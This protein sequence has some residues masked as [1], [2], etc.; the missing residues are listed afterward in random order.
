MRCTGTWFA[1]A[2]RRSGS[3]RSRSPYSPSVHLSQWPNPKPRMPMPSSLAD[4]ALAQRVVS[5]GRA[6]AQA[7]AAN[8]KMRQ[9]LAEAV[10]AACPAPRGH[11]VAGPPGRRCGEGKLNV[12]S[13]KTVGRGQRP[14][15]RGDPRTAQAAR[16]RTRRHFPTAIKAALADS[17]RWSWTRWNAGSP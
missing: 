8:L 17:I 15:R 1:A 5:L 13:L 9:P 11:G 6:D 10:V 16:A 7:E 4:M 3:S 12:K 14:G 2:M